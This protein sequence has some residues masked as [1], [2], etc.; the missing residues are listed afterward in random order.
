MG[1]YGLGR[2]E[3]TIRH[4]EKFHMASGLWVPA[5]QIQTQRF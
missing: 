5:R 1:S 4:I 3:M 2:P